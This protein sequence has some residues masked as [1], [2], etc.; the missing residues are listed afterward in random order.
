MARLGRGLPTATDKLTGKEVL[1]RAEG[2]LLKLSEEGEREG[3][4]EGGCG[5]ICV[6]VCVCESGRKC[7]WE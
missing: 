6:C 2:A 7:V 1:A 3:E 5:W 4:R